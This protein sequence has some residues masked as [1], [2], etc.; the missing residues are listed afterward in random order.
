MVDAPANLPLADRE[1]IDRLC[2]R[3]AERLGVGERPD[4]TTALAQA[5]RGSETLLL[6]RLL[7]VEGRAVGEADSEAYVERRLA[8]FPALSDGVRRLLC[9]EREGQTVHLG[10]S[11]AAAAAEPRLDDELLDLLSEWSRRR[12]LGESVSAEELAPHDSALASRLRIAVQDLLRADR[13]AATRDE[14]FGTRSNDTDA[15]GAFVGETLRPDLTRE[16]SPPLSVPEAKR[17]LQFVDSDAVVARAEAIARETAATDGRAILRRLESEKRLTPFQLERLL[18]DRPESLSL[19]AY[20]LLGTLGQGGMGQVFLARHRAMNRAVAVKLLPPNMVGSPESVS[21]FRRE[22]Q[23][24]ARLA[25]PNIVCAYDAGDSR[26]Q[27]YLAMEYVEGEDLAARVRRTGPF[28]TVEALN[29]LDQAAAGLEYAHA[30][31]MIHRDIKPSNLLIDA[32]GKVKIVDFG[33]A[34]LAESGDPEGSADLTSTNAMMGTVDF[35]APEQASDARKADQRADIYSLGCTFYYLLAGRAPFRGDSAVA[36]VLAHRDAPIPSLREIDPSA[37][38]SSEDLFR[39]MLA[40]R[41]EDR[42]GSM[43]DVRRALAD[44]RDEALRAKAVEA[45]ESKPRRDARFGRGA[46]VAASVAMLLVGMLGA[47][48]L[49]LIR[50]RTPHGTIV[51]EVNE[52]GALIEVLEGSKVELRQASDGEKLVISV[53]P[54]S[55][56]LKISKDGFEIFVKEFVLGDDES[57]S[58]VARLEPLSLPAALASDGPKSDPVPDSSPESRSE[59]SAAV[60][61]KLSQVAP[62]EGVMRGLVPRPAP[63]PG[64]ARWQARV[65]SREGYVAAW[66]PDGSRVAYGDLSGAVTIVDAVSGRA[67]KTFVAHEG[68]IADLEWNVDGTLL[69]TAGGSRAKVW[70]EEGELKSELVGHTGAVYFLSWSPDGEHLATTGSWGDATVRIWSSDGTQRHL[71]PHEGVACG[72]AWS[73]DGKTLASSDHGSRMILLSDAQDG[74]EV[75]RLGP[76]ADPHNPCLAWSP[77]GKRLASGGGDWDKAKVGGYIWDV[78]ERKAAVELR[79]ENTWLTW[80]GWSSDGKLAATTQD[81][82]VLIYDPASGE[83]LQQTPQQLSPAPANAAWSP[84]GDRLADASA[85][86]WNV[87]NGGRELVPLVDRPRVRPST[88]PRYEPAKFD[89]VAWSPQ[90]N[91]FAATGQEGLVFVW[92]ADGTLERSL[93]GHAGRQIRSAAWSPDGKRLATG[94]WDDYTLRLWNLDDGTSL[95]LKGHTSGISSLAFRPDGGRIASASADGTAKLWNLDGTSGP[96]LEG[97]DGGVLCVAWNSDGTRLATAGDDGTVRTWTAEGAL[98]RTL[99]GHNGPVSCVDWHPNG[100][101]LASVGYYDSCLLIWKLDSAESTVVESAHKGPIRQV[102]W[103]PDGKAVATLGWEDET[104]RLWDEQGAPGPSV[105]VPYNASAIDWTTDGDRL[106]ASAYDGTIRIWNS[107]GEL[108]RVLLHLGQ[109]RSALLGATGEWLNGDRHMLEGSLVYFVEAVEGDA[110]GLAPTAFDSF[111][112]SGLSFAEWRGLNPR[113]DE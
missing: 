99:G 42:F 111:V 5:P 65:G 94:G 70:S 112:E 16:D 2:D 106:A 34:R 91:R 89:S 79:K 25:H 53:E 28:S 57:T 38:A 37:P 22:M 8:A 1:R 75:G 29:L 90:G 56:R 83:V 11:R 32:H 93:S 78:V 21:R 55:K 109:G 27:H 63:L 113:L 103:R 54:G 73:P 45:A 66:H 6:L 9:V 71:I 23:A 3:Y 59:D 110:S 102:A 20:V 47:Y 69:A 44:A 58:V 87:E 95:E 39:R 15:G 41:P 96:S 92:N 67:V 85:R 48:G 88:Q 14:T 101:R 60:P 17:R 81:D 104:L 46:I 18:S 61:A 97:H 72:V 98:D 36:R 64:V 30:R 82:Y 10:S 31:G 19:A 68:G 52:P 35:M 50:V 49:T 77:D 43:A 7:L 40:K 12:D 24:A 107:E 13:F 105:E 4:V 76:V 84:Q 33:L 26:G 74:R 86:I 51:L 80:L 108:D 62:A 100:D